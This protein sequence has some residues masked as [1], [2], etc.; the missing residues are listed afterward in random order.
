MDLARANDV[1]CAFDAA[2][3]G[4]W[5]VGHRRTVIFSAA[6]LVVLCSLGFLKLN[7]IT[8]SSQLWV[9]ENSRSLKELQTIQQVNIIPLRC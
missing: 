3:T 2:T 4:R 5:A 8:D 9:P 7:S 6:A 1:A